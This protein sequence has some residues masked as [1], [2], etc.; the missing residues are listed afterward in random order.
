MAYR[1]I[2]IRSASSIFGPASAFLK[3]NGQEI[4]FQ[5]RAAALEELDRLRA[6]PTNNVHYSIVEDRS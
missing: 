1:I 2:C 3:S 5:D 4:V 6:K